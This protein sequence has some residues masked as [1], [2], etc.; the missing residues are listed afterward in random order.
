MGLLIGVAGPIAGCSTL[1]LTAELDQSP[2][3][4]LGREVAKAV[5]APGMSECLLS[6]PRSNLWN[7]RVEDDPGSG[8]SRNLLV[9]VD[10][11]GCWLAQ[12]VRFERDGP[13]DPRSRLSIGDLHGFG[14]TF[15]GCTDPES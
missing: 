7:C 4:K 11:S 6:R 14:R 13:T 1:D 8:W 12:H 15:T 5:K 2:G 3:A 9:K 10:E